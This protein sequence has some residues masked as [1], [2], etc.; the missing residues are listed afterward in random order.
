MTMESVPPLVHTDATTFV[1]A[2]MALMNLVAVSICYTVEPLYSGLIGTSDFMEVSLLWR[3]NYTAKVKL[4]RVSL[5][6]SFL[7]IE[8]LNREVPL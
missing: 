3:S 6:E 4:Y 1:I 7:Y 5:I 8:V 2:E